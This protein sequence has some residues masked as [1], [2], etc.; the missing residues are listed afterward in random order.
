MALPAM[1]SLDSE[2]LTTDQS[3]FEPCGNPFCNLLMTVKSGKRFCSDR[4]WMDGYVLRRTKEMIDRVGI[5]K[6]NS[7]LEGI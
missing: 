6:F 3:G 4:C 1:Q 7:I 5:I 2:P